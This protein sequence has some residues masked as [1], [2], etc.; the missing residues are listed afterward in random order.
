MQISNGFIKIDNGR[1]YSLDVVDFFEVR[2]TNQVGDNQVWQ[3]FMAFKDDERSS[4]S[5][6]GYYRTEEEA[7]EELDNCLEFSRMYKV[8]LDGALYTV[9]GG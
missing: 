9:P 4:K 3:I 5:I 8:K 2:K 1:W 6:S 7:E